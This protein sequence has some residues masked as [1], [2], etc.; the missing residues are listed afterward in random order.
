MKTHAASLLCVGLFL[1]LGG[2]G[3]SATLMAGRKALR[4]GELGR[5]GK[6]CAEVS[7]SGVE[8]GRRLAAL[9]CWLESARRRGRLDEVDDDLA[10]RPPSGL[11]LYGRALAR[12]ARDPSH[13]EEASR[14]LARAA[15]RWPREAEIPY[16][17]AVIL[18]ADGRPREALELLGRCEDLERSARCAL[19]TGH[20]LLDLGRAE[21]AQKKLREAATRRLSSVDVGRG[22]ALASRLARRSRRAPAGAV[23]DLKRAKAALEANKQSAALP[24]LRTL[25]VDYPQLGYAY[26]LLGVALLAQEEMAEAVVAFR[27]ASR[28]CPLDPANAFYLGLIYES[29]GRLSD[30]EA[31]Y[32]AALERDPFLARAL[33]RLG[34]LLTQRKRQREAAKVF[35]RLASI[36]R[37]ARALRLAG[38]AHL[39][40]GAWQAARSRYER[41][42]TGAPRDFEAHL[43]LGEILLKRL[44]ASPGGGADQGESREQLL[45]KARDH[46]A[47]AASI[48]PTDAA[49]RK[50]LTRLKEQQ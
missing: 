48:R 42:L 7:R 25:T 39:A 6:L 36:S 35:D 50:L 3:E 40:A 29:R 15:K 5:A 23:R 22:R 19:A 12:L 27:R 45:K 37:G 44:A 21:E 49:V 33:S 9:R 38:R 16:R 13:V 24:L 28:L 10:R 17:Q 8:R 34:K 30:A 18:L 26:S 43:R 2:C 1:P 46:A 11:T 14:L 47:A 41:V 32:R 4:L 31:S 20:A